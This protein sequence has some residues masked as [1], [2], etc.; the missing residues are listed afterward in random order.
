MCL[1]NAWLVIYVVPTPFRGLTG[2][3][4]HH[5]SINAKDIYS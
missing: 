2:K 1:H 3:K 5:A 4:R